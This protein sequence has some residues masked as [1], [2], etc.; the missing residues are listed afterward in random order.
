MHAAIFLG[1]LGGETLIIIVVILLLFGGDKLPEIMRGIGKGVGEIR[2]ATD[3]I[4]EEIN[5]VDPT[6]DLKKDE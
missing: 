2:K 4:K 1:L 3:S 5:N 6:K